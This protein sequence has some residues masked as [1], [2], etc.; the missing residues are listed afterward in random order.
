[1][2][3]AAS[4]ML[5]G[6]MRESVRKSVEVLVK[7]AMGGLDMCRVSVFSPAFEYFWPSYD[8]RFG[9]ESREAN[10]FIVGDCAG[11]FRGILQ[12]FCSGLVCADS[13]IGKHHG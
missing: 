10:V 2:L 6:E 5:P 4:H 11:Q 9:F 7:D 1:M 8:L 12:A 13:V 3:G